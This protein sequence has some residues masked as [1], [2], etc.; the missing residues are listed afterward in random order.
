[1]TPT[2][3][4]QRLCEVAAAEQG[5]V[6]SLK[7]WSEVL[8]PAWHGPPPKHWCGAFTLWALRTVLGCEWT[9]EVNGVLGAK[10][11]GYLYRLPMTKRP[12]PGDVCYMNAPY[13]HHALLIATGIDGYVMTQDGNSGNSPGVCLACRRPMSAWTAF[14]SIEPLLAEACK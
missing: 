13:Q 7:Y 2:Q 3:L 5:S 1:M 11:S 12:L 8:P 4:R 10:H 14:Y 6:D 9:W